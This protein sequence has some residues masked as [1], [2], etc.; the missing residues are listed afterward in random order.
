MEWNENC[1]CKILGLDGDLRMHM[2]LVKRYLECVRCKHGRLI[3]NN[4]NEV[5]V[6]QNEQNYVVCNFMNV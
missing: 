2:D 4:R 5:R 3:G 6:L 1:I